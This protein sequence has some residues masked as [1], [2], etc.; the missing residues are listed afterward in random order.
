MRPIW[1]ALFCFFFSSISFLTNAEAP[2]ELL[3]LRAL[4]LNNKFEQLEQHLKSA[5]DLYLAKKIPLREYLL[6]RNTL[7]LKSDLNNPKQIINQ[8]ESWSKKTQS[9]YAYSTLGSFYRSLGYHQRGGKWARET[10]SEEFMGMRTSF[11][12]A[13]KY[14][15]LSKN[16]DPT[17]LN[18]YITVANM[19]KSMP[20]NHVSTNNLSNDYLYRFYISLP[21]PI[22]VLLRYF[23]PNI[24]TPATHTRYEVYQHP[25]F[26]DAPEI[27]WQRGA[28]WHEILYNSTPRWG[29]SYKEM[30]TIIDE[31]I[32]KNIPD[33]TKDDQHFYESWIIADKA[34]ILYKQKKYKKGYKLTKNFVRKGTSATRAMRQAMYFSYKNEDYQNCHL[35]SENLAHQ[36]PWNP[37]YWYYVG[38]CSFKLERWA[39]MNSAFKHKL[40]LN[41]ENKY[42]LHQLGVSYMYLKQYDKAYPLFLK[43]KAIDPEYKQWTD[44]YTDFIEN[45]KPNDT[46]LKNK[47]TQELIGK[48][49]YT[50]TER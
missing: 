22:Q 27:I 13:I 10:S 31:D 49:I 44:Q 41:G 36:R 46:R 12:N 9:A 33:F 15:K 29:G 24:F 2:K 40:L 18:N 43:A 38:E 35:Y 42:D 28:I 6:T 8:L 39:S 14:L 11:D 26:K 21:T 4:L 50:P 5:N 45:E 37:K 23:F 30:H 3:Y 32:S 47:T 20:N 1:L 17:I 25:F 16:T 19:A 48:L 34:Q 7:W